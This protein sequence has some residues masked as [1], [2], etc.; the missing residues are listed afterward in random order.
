MT[1][2]G[3]SEDFKKAAVQKMLLRGSKSVTTI[4]EELGVSTPTIY[5]WKRLYAISEGMTTSPKRPQD[6]TSAEK[7]Q[8]VL[9]FSRLSDE[10]EQGEFLRRKGLHTAHIEKWKKQMQGG[11]E[12][13]GSA[14]S[15]E[16]KAETTQLKSE[17]NSLKK[18]LQRKDRA[19]AETTALLVLKKKANSLWGNG[20]DE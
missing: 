18:D 5:E 7:F 1:T 11:L 9:E 15:R 20:E 13:E 4:C 10:Q 14:P 6:W 3:Y 19:L 12:N 17:L 8:A 16:A 2:L